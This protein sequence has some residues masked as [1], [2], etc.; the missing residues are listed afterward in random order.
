MTHKAS[1]PQQE[2][3]E[4]QRSFSSELDENS[5]FDGENARKKITIND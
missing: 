2:I 1:H 4:K 5:P 3:V